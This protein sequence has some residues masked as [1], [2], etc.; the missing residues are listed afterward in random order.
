MQSHVG[1]RTLQCVYFL[2]CITSH[3]EPRLRSASSV[4]PQRRAAEDDL[5]DEWTSIYA[6][7]CYGPNSSFTEPSCNCFGEPKRE[8]Y[9]SRRRAVIIAIGSWLGAAIDAFLLKTVIEE[10]FGYPTILVSNEEIEESQKGVLH[11][12]GWSDEDI[13]AHSRAATIFPDLAKGMAVC[14]PARPP[15]HACICVHVRS[16]AR[17][18]LSLVLSVCTAL[19]CMRVMHV[20]EVCISVCLPVCMIVRLYTCTYVHACMDLTSGLVHIYPEVWQSKEGREY[21]KYVEEDGT[22]VTVRRVATYICCI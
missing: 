18:H 8:A 3:A 17:A 7:H 2:L 22:V 15:V 1:S 13:K 5:A 4:R 20:M 10:Q 12:E 16:Y 14:P 21:K 11:K 6:M 19:A 9:H